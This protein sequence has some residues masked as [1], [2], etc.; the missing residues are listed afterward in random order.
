MAKYV[1]CFVLV[2]LVS[3]VLALEKYTAQ[4]EEMGTQVR[5]VVYSDDGK[6]AIQAANAAL[7]EFNRLNGIMSD[8]LSESEVRK[9]CDTTDTQSPVCLSDELYTVLQRAAEVSK[10]SGGAFDVTVGPVVKLWRRARRQKQLPTKE[11]LAEAKQW[12]GW[13]NVEL[14]A[15]NKVL[16]KK[17]GM[18]IDLGGIAK[19]YALESAM[20]VLKK[21]GVKHALIDAGG[22]IVLSEPPPGKKTWSI[23]IESLE[24]GQILRLAG[25]N[26]SDSPQATA[27]AGTT[28]DVKN[29]AVT[30]S[31]DL[32]QYTEIDGV[33]YSH[34][35]DPAT[36]L[37][38]TNRSTV[39]VV[40]PSATL[41]DAYASALS[42]LGPKKGLALIEK[43][44]Q[45]EARIVTLEN[46][47]VKVYPSSGWKFK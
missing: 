38:L 21:R 24:T 2:W 36:G 30:T 44:P 42:V 15:G 40:G 27:N 14:L 46:N 26:A 29:V 3:P 10:V 32:W 6:S 37:G 17:T 12:V 23:L 39:T 9:I 22:D 45:Y 25:Q 28:L 18:R 43:M 35:V 13:Q 34:I 31:G 33:R 41:S 4:R 7:D 8:Y 47:K 1:F 19:G 11:N 20:A 16:V 5:I